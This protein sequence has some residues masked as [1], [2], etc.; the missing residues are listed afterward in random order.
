MEAAKERAVVV[1]VGKFRDLHQPRITPMQDACEQ[2]QLR[3]CTYKT[4][5]GPALNLW[6]R[7]RQRMRHSSAT[8]TTCRQCEHASR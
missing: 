8:L 3:H 4:R 1:V 5:R 6:R 7:P 2:D